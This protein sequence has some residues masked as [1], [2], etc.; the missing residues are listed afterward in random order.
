LLTQKADEYVSLMP[1][2]GPDLELTKPFPRDKIIPENN[3]DAKIRNDSKKK[4]I[5]REM[6]R[7]AKKSTE[8]SSISA[9]FYEQ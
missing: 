2:N 8:I 6:K 7:A 3:G 1:L 5:L 9:I 4:W